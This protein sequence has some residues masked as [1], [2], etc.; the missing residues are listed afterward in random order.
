MNGEQYLTIEHLEYMK[1]I[2]KEY[3][4]NATFPDPRAF[5]ELE[6]AIERHITFHPDNDCD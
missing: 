1:E 4:L 2:M 3:A 5:I 6:D